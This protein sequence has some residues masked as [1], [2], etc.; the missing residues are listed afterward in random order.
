[1][2]AEIVFLEETDAPV[3][4]RTGE[5]TIQTSVGKFVRAYAKTIGIPF[6]M[7]ERG[8]FDRY[9]GMSFAA[10]GG[11]HYLCFRVKD[12]NDGK[13]LD[14]G[15]VDYEFPDAEAGWGPEEARE[16]AGVI[17]NLMTI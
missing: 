11:V 9:G 17:H 8:A 16:V 14:T 15:G 2:P 13:V 7:V 5:G 3:A 1:M 6:R 10:S 12:G 4:Y